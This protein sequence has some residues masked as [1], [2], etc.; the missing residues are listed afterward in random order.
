M[1]NGAAV[2][3]KSSVIRCRDS[4]RIYPYVHKPPEPLRLRVES[5]RQLQ[6]C[7]RFQALIICPAVSKPMKKT[8]SWYWIPKPWRCIPPVTLSIHLCILIA[9]LCTPTGRSPAMISSR[10]SYKNSMQHK[11]ICAPASVA[12]IAYRCDQ[13]QTIRPAIWI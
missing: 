5:D 9:C 8:A 10:F 2:I 3:R 13:I 4:L 6:P 12:D 1:R 7:P 11:E